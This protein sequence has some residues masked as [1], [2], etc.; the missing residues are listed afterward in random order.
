[1]ID[2]SQQFIEERILTWFPQFMELAMVMLKIRFYKG[3]LKIT[4]GYL[5]LDLQTLEDVKA[6]VQGK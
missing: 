5:E 2:L 3:V 6:E 4:K 1:K